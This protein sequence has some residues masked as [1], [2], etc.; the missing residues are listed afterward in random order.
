MTAK[1]T[2]CVCFWH[3]LFILFKAWNTMDYTLFTIHSHHAYSVDLHDNTNQVCNAVV[4]TKVIISV[5]YHN[6][7]VVFHIFFA[8]CLLKQLLL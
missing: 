1:F 7:L 6:Y 8:N 3:I 5:K 2:V 4:K